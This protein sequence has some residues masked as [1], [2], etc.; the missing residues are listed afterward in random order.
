LY[1][2]ISVKSLVKVESNGPKGLKPP[3]VSL[4][5]T[6]IPMIPLPGSGAT[7]TGVGILGPCPNVPAS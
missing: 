5:C 6:S 1:I 3:P 4:C 2:S 7:G